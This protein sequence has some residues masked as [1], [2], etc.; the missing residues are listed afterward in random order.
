ML[1]GC[2]P[3]GRGQPPLARALALEVKLDSASLRYGDTVR[4]RF[5]LKNVSNAPVE[6]CTLEEGVSTFLRLDGT[7]VPLK[8]Y[9]VGADVGCR[10]VTLLAAETREY[11]EEFPV[12]PCPTAGEF[13]GS[14]RLYTPN[15]EDWAEAASAPVP[16][17][18]ARPDRALPPHCAAITR[19]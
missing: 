19:R 7:P 3:S 6:F 15:G 4:A 2:A 13:A 10:P 12:W 8:G 11:V 17:T 16:V 18:I 9:G 5:L 14:I 1:V